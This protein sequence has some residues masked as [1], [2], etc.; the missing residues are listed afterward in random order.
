LWLTGDEDVHDRSLLAA[1]V[2]MTGSLGAA[3]SFA[4]LRMTRAFDRKTFVKTLHN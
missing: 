4:S 3:R 2:G 1:L